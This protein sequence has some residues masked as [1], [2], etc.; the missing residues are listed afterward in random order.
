MAQY[1][2]RDMVG[3]KRS[4]EDVAIKALDDTMEQCYNKLMDVIDKDVYKN[5]KHEYN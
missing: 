4:L 3:L 1:V 2:F 5:A